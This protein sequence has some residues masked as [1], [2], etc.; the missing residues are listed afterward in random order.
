VVDASGL[1]HDVVAGAA[2]LMSCY[3]KAL[4]RTQVLNCQLEQDLASEND[5]PECA[6][7]TVMEYFIY[8]GNPVVPFPKYSTANYSC[9]IE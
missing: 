9:Y 1:T 2:S 7:T 6:G 5:Q 4:A 3:S 8:F